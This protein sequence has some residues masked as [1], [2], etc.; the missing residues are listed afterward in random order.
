M[1]RRLVT[2]AG[3]RAERVSFVFASIFPL[4]LAVRLTQRLTR[5]FR[6]PR[7][8][9]DIRVPSGPVN[10]LLTAAVSAEAALARHVRM[11]IGSSLLVVARKEQ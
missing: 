8:D 10:Q 7:A 2:D 11:P 4:M 6:V 5:R 1:A 9:V 3:L